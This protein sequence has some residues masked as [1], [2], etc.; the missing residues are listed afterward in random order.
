MYVTLASASAALE[1]SGMDI[2][3]GEFYFPKKEICRLGANVCARIHRSQIAVY[4]ALKI[5]KKIIMK[6]PLF[7]V[8]SWLHIAG[9]AHSRLRKFSHRSSHLPSRNGAV[10]CGV[11]QKLF[12]MSS[13]FYSTRLQFSSQL[14]SIKYFII[15]VLSIYCMCGGTGQTLLRLVSYYFS[16]CFF[17]LSVY[18]QNTKKIWSFSH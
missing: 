6:N 7:D 16:I 17:S 13:V 14:Y 4:C 15:I 5:Q 3:C 2:A 8:S 9:I 1:A 12:K 11:L 18:M 10:L